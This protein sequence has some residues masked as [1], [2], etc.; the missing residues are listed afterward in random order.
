MRAKM[1]CFSVNDFG[2]TEQVSLG[3]VYSSDPAHP[4]HAWSKASP[5]ATLSI[6][7]SNPAARGQF[8]PGKEYFIDFTEADPTAA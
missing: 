8:K 4:N 3:A 7:I 5:S 2:T 6:T 1:Q